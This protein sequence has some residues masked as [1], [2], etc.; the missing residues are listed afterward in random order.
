MCSFLVDFATNRNFVYLNEEKG[1]VHK[2]NHTYA[3]APFLVEISLEFGRR[4][5]GKS[6]YVGEDKTAKGMAA[7]HE[8]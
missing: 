2:L 5:G 4:Q 7:V 8:E 1:A 6:R 3:T